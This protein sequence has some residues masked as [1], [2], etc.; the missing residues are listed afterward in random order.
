MVIIKYR[1]WYKFD[2]KAAK[3]F[4]IR[5]A[6]T[7]LELSDEYFDKVLEKYMSASLLCLDVRD[8][9]LG[10]DSDNLILRYRTLADKPSPHIPSDTAYQKAIVYQVPKSHV[11]DTV[12]EDQTMTREIRE[13]NITNPLIKKSYKDNLITIED[14]RQDEIDKVYN[15]NKKV[16]ALVL[17]ETKLDELSVR[18]D[19][20]K[21]SSA[22]ISLLTLTDIITINDINARFAIDFDNLNKVYFE[23]NELFK[24]TTTYEQQRALFIEYNIIDDFSN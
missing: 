9:Q 7:M 15:S 20:D 4:Y 2:N 14:I 17:I 12:K 21:M 19:R 18:Y 5:H 3:E 11:E 1:Q 6:L 10:T 16:K 13:L 24:L 23:L 8:E 22:K